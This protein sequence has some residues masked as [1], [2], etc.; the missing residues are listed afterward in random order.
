V[1][2]EQNCNKEKK[3]H[4]QPF[5]ASKGWRS[6]VWKHREVNID[7]ESCCWVARQVVSLAVNLEKKKTMEDCCPRCNRGKTGSFLQQ[8]GFKKDSNSIQAREVHG[9]RTKQQ[10]YQRLKKR[11]SRC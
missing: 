4:V 9:R 2:V 8:R 3:I 6:K 7:L 5:E 10:T 11:G 1:H